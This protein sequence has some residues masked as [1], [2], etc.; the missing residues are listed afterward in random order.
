MAERRVS[1]LQAANA[2]AN[3]LHT[4]PVK[5]DGQGRKSQKVIGYGATVV[6]NPETRGI[7]TAYP[8]GKGK[9]RK[10]GAD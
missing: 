7:I 6:I 4:E 5:V 8:T 1:D 2:L 3:P 9:R 10:Y